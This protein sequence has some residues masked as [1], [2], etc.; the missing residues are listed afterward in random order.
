MPIQS[1]RFSQDPRSDVELFHV[2]QD[3]IVGGAGRLVVLVWRRRTTIEGVRV[4]REYV[5]RRCVRKGDDFAI[6]S[7]VEAKATLPDSQARHAIA[8]MLQNGDRCFQISGLVFEGTG[9]FAATIRSVVTGITLMAKQNYPHRVFDSVASAA[10]FFE[11]EQPAGNSRP[12]VAR[13]IERIVGELRRQA[14]EPG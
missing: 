11:R 4:C 8:E 5:A 13:D 10:R 3:L 7:I 9:F 12:L 1:A 6:M 14:R 2:D